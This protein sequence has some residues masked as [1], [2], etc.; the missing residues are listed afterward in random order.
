M[1]VVGAKSNATL[2]KKLKI[3][4]KRVGA[5]Q[6]DV[7]RATGVAQATISRLEADPDTRMVPD[8]ADALSGWVKKNEAR[9]ARSATNLK[10]EARKKFKL[11]KKAA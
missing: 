5:T 11:Q 10:S 6:A 1:N 3:T 9:V 8:T 2:V 7:A 4:R